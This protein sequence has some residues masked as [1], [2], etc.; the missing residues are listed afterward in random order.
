MAYVDVMNMESS[1]GRCRAL[2]TSRGQMAVTKQR[3][4]TRWWNTGDGRSMVAD[5][6]VTL[7]IEKALFTVPKLRISQPGSTSLRV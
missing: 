2:Y 1:Y 5:S 7:S 6:G 3:T 4:S